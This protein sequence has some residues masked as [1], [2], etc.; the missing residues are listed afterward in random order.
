MSQTYTADDA[1]HWVLLT[2]AAFAARRSELDALNVYPVPDGDTGTNL[3]LT[4]DGALD[5]VIEAHTR[6]GILGTASLV[7]ECE[8]LSRAVLLSGRGNS[9][10]ILGQILRGLCQVVIE[11]QYVDLDAS[12]IATC[13]ER[14]ASMA[15]KAVAHPQEGTILSVADAAAAA[16]RLAADRGDDLVPVV[17]AALEGAQ[18]A[19]ARTPEQLEALARAGVVDA[20][21]AGCVLMLESLHRVL[22]GAWSGDLSDVLGGGTALIRRDEWHRAGDESVS[23]MAVDADVIEVSSG[24]R[25]SHTGPDGASDNSL[26][27]PDYEVMYLVEDSDEDRVDA[28]TVVLDG[29]GDSLIVVGGP[30]L[31]SV[32]VHVDDVGAAIEAGIDAGRLR[33]IIVTNFADQIGR[34]RERNT[35]GVVACAAGP[36]IA[37]ILKEAGAV[38]VSSSPGARASAGQLLEGARATGAHSV[39]LLPN[40]KDTVLAA[41]AAVTAAA[42]EG[43]A[44]HVIPART[45]VQGLA[46]MAVHDP[47]MSVQDNVIAMAGAA[48]ATR[49]GAVTI[50]S[51]EALTSGGHCVPGDALG[52]VDGD[53]VLVGDDLAEIAIE[54]VQRLL[55]AGGEL[56]TLLTGEGATPELL[57]RL[58][59]AIRDE[60]AHAEVIVLEGGQSAYPLLIGVE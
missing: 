15:R 21:G 23:V 43:M 30:D 2:R 9:G 18:V 56:V 54:V 50:A 42:Q 38:V 20:G 4:L 39:L 46:A 22:T 34:H 44:V 19:L 59:D 7:E 17:E 13:F 49:H 51:K 36:G 58:E 8:T 26:A 16:A 33:R 60:A 40:D 10:V 45:A 41:E 48:R 25:S 35:I 27:G 31:W 3:Y 32:H 52:I 28:L 29:L 5:Q 6:R 11:N 37:A 55:R 47:T 53:I 24:D 57:S 12:A 14:G 1:R